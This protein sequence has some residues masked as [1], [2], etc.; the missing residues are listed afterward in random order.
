MLYIGE[1]GSGKSFT[2]TQAGTIT[3]NNSQRFFN[4]FQSEPFYQEG[5]F[6]S[7][8]LLQ[9]LNG[10]LEGL[11]DAF[12]QVFSSIGKV[13]TLLAMGSMTIITFGLAVFIPIWTIIY[14]Y[15]QVDQRLRVKA[16]RAQRERETQERLRHHPP[17]DGCTT[18]TRSSPIKGLR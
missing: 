15:D 8:V 4:H 14:V 5:S 7:M 11:F 10:Q 3:M 18:S 16:Y 2:G 12:A 17:H 1:E 6:R 13:F 9:A